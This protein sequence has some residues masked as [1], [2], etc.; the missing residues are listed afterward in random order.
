MRDA[1]AIAATIT[2]VALLGGCG[3]NGES[4]ASSVPD[5]GGADQTASSESQSSHFWAAVE[6][7]EY[8]YPEALTDEERSEGE[9]SSKVLMFRYLGVNNGVYKVAGDDNGELTIAECQKDCAVI[10]ITDPNGAVEYMTFNATSIVGEA[11]T[12][13][14]DGQL[15]QYKQGTVP[16]TALPTWSPSS[17]VLA[18]DVAGNMANER[19]SEPVQTPN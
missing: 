1:L 3:P 18:D 5:S 9:A 15:E 17:G 6:D 8:A 16:E 4:L 2:A 19:S 11:L 14:F 13:A 12:D 7:G 10:K